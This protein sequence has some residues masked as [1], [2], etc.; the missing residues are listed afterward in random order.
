MIYKSYCFVLGILLISSSLASA[1]M[2]PLSMP[3]HYLKSR[4]HKIINLDQYPN[5]VVIAVTGKMYYPDIQRYV[6]SSDSCISGWPLEDKYTFGIY[7][8]NRDLFKDSMLTDYHEVFYKLSPDIH[9]MGSTWTD[10]GHPILP[11]SHLYQ[12][13]EEP[14]IGETR[15]FKIGESPRKGG[16]YLYVTKE[17]IKYNDGRP[18]KIQDFS[19]PKASDIITP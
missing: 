17:T 15:L 4:C 3:H 2:A 14:S 8:I 6:V 5:I 9:Q 19:E 12:P 1:D 11:S 13:D 7:W 16:F 10:I 18:E